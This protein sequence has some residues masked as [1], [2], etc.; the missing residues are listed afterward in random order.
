MILN[1]LAALVRNGLPTAGTVAP[2]FHSVRQV[3]ENIDADLAKRGWVCNGLQ[4]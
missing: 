4:R 2:S 3:A 1:R